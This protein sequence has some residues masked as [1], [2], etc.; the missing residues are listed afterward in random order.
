V[1]LSGAP[2][3]VMPSPRALPHTKF[4]G[5]VESWDVLSHDVSSIFH[6][7]EFI[8]SL[9]LHPLFLITDFWSAM[10]IQRVDQP[11]AKHLNAWGRPDPRGGFRCFW[12]PNKSWTPPLGA[13]DT[14]IIV[15]KNKIR[16]EKVPAPQSKG[17]RTQKTKSLNITK[18]GS[19]TLKKFPFMLLCYY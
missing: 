7:L 17:V 19:R 4:P 3:L 16:N 14:L 11:V 1:E 2:V 18:V 12:C 6:L 13:S 5:L 9:N 8:S 15:K 10:K